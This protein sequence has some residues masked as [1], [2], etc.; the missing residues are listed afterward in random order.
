MRMIWYD[1]SSPPL[2]PFFL[3]N[4]LFAF[5][6]LTMRIL[7]LTPAGEMD[8]FLLKAWVEGEAG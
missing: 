8:I 4:V 1:L 3:L 5:L 2:S 6:G 7:A